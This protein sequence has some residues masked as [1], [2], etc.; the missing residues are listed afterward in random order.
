MRYIITYRDKPEEG[1]HVYLVTYACELADSGEQ[2]IDQFTAKHPDKVVLSADRVDDERAAF[3]RYGMGAWTDEEQQAHREKLNENYAATARERE[4]A[5]QIVSTFEPD[6]FAAVV[7]YLDRRGSEKTQNLEGVHV[8][9]LFYVSWGYDQTNYTYYQVVGLRGKHT[10]VVRENMAHRASFGF[11]QGL[12]RPLRNQFRDDERHTL[13]TRFDEQ[14]GELWIKS[15]HDY[16]C[17]RRCKD[18]EF[19][20]YTSY[21]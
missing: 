21:A 9:D 16:G 15:P 7:A 11:M 19:H 3:E 17:L 5:E 1:K 14:T 18:G 10:I 13:R 12:S 8:G 4:E 2:A 20:N 6:E